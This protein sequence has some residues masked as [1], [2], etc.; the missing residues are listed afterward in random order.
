MRILRDIKEF[1]ETAFGVVGALILYA[2]GSLLAVGIVI[3]T[4]RAIMWVVSNLW[5]KMSIGG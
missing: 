4:I 2:V 5:L 1:M 3:G